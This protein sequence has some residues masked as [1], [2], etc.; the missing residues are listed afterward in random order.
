MYEV[1][2]R[3]MQYIKTY[4]DNYLHGIM[5]LSQQSFSYLYQVT[6]KVYFKFMIF[7]KNFT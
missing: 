6:F 1:W 2:F 3:V 7:Q 5:F 4:Y